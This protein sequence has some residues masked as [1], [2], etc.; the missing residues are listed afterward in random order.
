MAGPARAVRQ[1][2]DLYNRF[3]RWARTGRWEAIFKDLQLDVDVVDSLADASVVRAHQDA[4]G[5]KGGLRSNALGRSRGGFSTKVHAVT[6]TNGK[7]L[8]LALTQGQQHESTMAQELLVH[9]E[10]DAFIADTAYDAD[11]IRSDVRK[12]GMKPVI[13]SHPGR[14]R[15]L[16]LGR[17]LYRL[18]CCFHDLKRFRA[19]ATHYDKT[20]TC[21]LAVLHV[22]AMLL[23]LH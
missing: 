10:G 20:A 7:P 15:R 18:E 13:H 6:T 1:L 4:S 12:L 17:P 19:V 14:K 11:H 9:A 16:P 23:W 3:H 22:A 5:G 8:H 21:Y 2:E